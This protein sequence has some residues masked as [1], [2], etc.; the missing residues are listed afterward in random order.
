[1]TIFHKSILEAEDLLKTGKNKEAW[2]IIEEHI[3]YLHNVADIEWDGLTKAYF[4]YRKA[5]TALPK[6]M[7]DFGVQIGPKPIVT[8]TDKKITL[9]QINELKRKLNKF[10]KLLYKFIKVEEELE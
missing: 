3:K 8:I 1:M 6:E 4:S 7:F 10:R 5:F 2:N 9:E